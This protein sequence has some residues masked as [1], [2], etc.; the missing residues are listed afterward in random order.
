MNITEVYGIEDDR[1]LLQDV[2]AFQQSGV[3]DGRVEGALR[4]TGI[5]PTFMGR[6]RAEGV[7]LPPG[8]FG[9]P[10]FDPA[11]RGQVRPGK[12]RWAS[13]DASL[14]GKP[15][16]VTVGHG[17][18]ARAG[19]MVYIS[20]MGPVDPETGAIVGVGV[21]EQTRQCMRNLKERLEAQ[22]SGLDRIVWANWALRD[23]A[24]FDVFDEEWLR[25][26][27]DDPPV[28]Q[29]TLMTPAHRRAGFRV[30]IGVIAQA[31]DDP[32]D[33]DDRGARHR[34]RSADG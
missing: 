32:P 18:V 8:E 16:P 7:D 10:A 13:E 27:P 3:R 21:R 19:G 11:R 33:A 25:W 17:R 4:P 5:R 20:S 24:D 2:F 34:G 6:F 26:F 12:S 15:P 9:I 30:A 23:P 29:A 31:N 28:G 1:I 22:G 14:D